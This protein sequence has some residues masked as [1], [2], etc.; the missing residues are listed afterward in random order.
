MTR[1]VRLSRLAESDLVDIW[2]HT[3][4][5]WSHEQADAYLDASDAALRRLAVHPEVGA[6]RDGVGDGYRV[7]FVGGHAVY[8]RVASSAVLVVRVLHGRMDPERHLL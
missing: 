1:K 2:R 3:A 5:Q 4:G 7:L 6:R 8:Y